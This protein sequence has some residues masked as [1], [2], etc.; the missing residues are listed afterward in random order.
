MGD[1]AKVID[2]NGT[3]VPTDIA[4]VLAQVPPGRYRLQAVTDDDG[5]ELTPEQE[6][7][8]EAAIRSADEGRTVPFEDA[9]A[10]MTAKLS[11]LR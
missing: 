6:A 2:W 4:E 5:F 9:M 7:G 10:R 1:A 3:D 11:A 8:I